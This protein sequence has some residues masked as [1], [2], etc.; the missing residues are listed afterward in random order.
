M[1]MRTII[2][3]N[4]TWSYNDN[5]NQCRNG[6]VF[7]RF[8]FVFLSCLFDVCLLEILGRHTSCLVK[9]DSHRTG[10]VTLSLHRPAGLERC[11]KIEPVI[12]AK[13]IRA[14][15]SRVKINS[16]AA[17]SLLPG[18]DTQVIQSSQLRNATNPPIMT[19]NANA[20]D[21]YG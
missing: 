5:T 7:V 3:S 19:A 15:M 8:C 1:F 12:I 4:L 16:S 17:T 18:G 2:T 21:K 11:P 14:P 13:C 6:V 9:C 20:D 10:A